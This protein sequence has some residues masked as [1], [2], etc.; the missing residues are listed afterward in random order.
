MCRGLSNFPHNTRT[1]WT[2]A[3]KIGLLL[4]SGRARR[5]TSPK[6]WRGER[7]KN[8]DFLRDFGEYRYQ[9]LLASHN[10]MLYLFLK[11]CVYIEMKKKNFSHNVPRNFEFPIIMDVH[12]IPVTGKAWRARNLVRG[13]TDFHYR[14]DSRVRNRAERV[15]E[16]GFVRRRQLH[17]GWNH[18]SCY[19]A[20][21]T[22]HMHALSCAFLPLHP[23][24]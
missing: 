4:I 23:R 9:A 16:F 17:D 7:R 21:C 1:R 22:L 6:F 3:E 11:V 13:A 14:S 19:P 12:V 2:R 18:M 5:P 10:H 20:A 8:W 24:S 15:V